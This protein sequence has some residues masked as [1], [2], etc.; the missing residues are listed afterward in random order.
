MLGVNPWSLMTW[1][2]HTTITETMRYVHVA[3]AH[4]R[5]IPA[6]VL[7]GAGG[8]VDPDRRILLMLGCRCILV[9]SGGAAT[10]KQEETQR[11]T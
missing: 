2:G 4:R 7:S 5:P 1:M 11:V 8:E 10:E 9:A 6:Q 3:N